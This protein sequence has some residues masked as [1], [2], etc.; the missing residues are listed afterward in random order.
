[1]HNAVLSVGVTALGNCG[2]WRSV[3][4]HREYQAL[5]IAHV[6]D[7]KLAGPP[8]DMKK[9]WEAIRTAQVFE[10]PGN[11]TEAI[12]LGPTE[13]VNSFLG[14]EH[15]VGKYANKDG[16]TVRTHI[17]QMHHFMF[18]CVTLR[19]DC[20][21]ALAWIRSQGV[22]L[23]VHQRGRLSQSGMGSSH[24]QRRKHAW[25]RVPQLHRSLSHRR[26]QASQEFT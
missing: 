13:D 1:M 7:F 22:R 8:D 14:C 21:E 11:W 9:A 16:K 12:Q 19:T 23:A 17:W 20:A 26:L 2:E 6:D 4:F 10:R 15:H 25:L 5:M 18:T 24:E 3:Y